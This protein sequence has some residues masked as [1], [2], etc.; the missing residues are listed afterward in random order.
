[1]AVQNAYDQRLFK[2]GLRKRIHES[3]FLW[4]EEQL[5]KRSDVKSGARLS[6]I[7]IGCFNCR[8]LKYLGFTPSRYYGLDAG[9]EEGVDEA[10]RT[11]PQYEIKK[12]VDPED[13]YGDWDLCLALE[14]LEH[15]PRPDVLEEY[16]ERIA[17]SS[18]TLIATVPMEIGPLFSAKFLYKKFIHG[19]KQSHTFWEFI[20]QSLGRCHVVTQDNHRGFDY[21]VLIRLIDRYFEIEK[22]E[23]LN[24]KLPKIMNTQIG[25]IAKSRIYSHKLVTS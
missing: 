16:L 6:V 9:W 18:K 2:S 25:I 15:L 17:I 24:S 19:Y 8:S 5:S 7:E 4:L 1:M 13:V 22:F 20:N 14:T 12:S 11:Y 21:R 3:R 23:G 10:I